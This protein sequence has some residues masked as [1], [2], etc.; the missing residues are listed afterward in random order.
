[1]KIEKTTMYLKGEFTKMQYKS[2]LKK[3][4]LALVLMV[5]ILMT[6]IGI[7]AN[8]AQATPQESTITNAIAGDEYDLVIG[9]AVDWLNNKKV[10]G[11][12]GDSNLVNETCKVLEI[13]NMLGIDTDVS[14]AYAW[15]DEEKYAANNDSLSR[16]IAINANNNEALAKL[17]DNQNTDGGFGLTSDYTSDTLDSLLAMEALMNT[18]DRGKN[19]AQLLISYLISAQNEDGGMGI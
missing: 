16:Y 11:I 19:E 17:L 1:M 12:W 14:D 13:F 7:T 8:A 4:L 3:R 10:D 9:N 18:K 6:S 2:T 15:L 5:G